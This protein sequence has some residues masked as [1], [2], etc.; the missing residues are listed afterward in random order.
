MKSSDA[1]TMA[2]AIFSERKSPFGA[3][4]LGSDTHQALTIPD[5][6]RRCHWIA[7]DL[8]ASEFGL[9]FV[10]PSVERPRLI[11]CFDSSYP[12]VSAATKYISGSNGE[13]IVKHTR[14]STL[15]RWWCDGSQSATALALEGLHEAVR[16][17]ELVPSIPGIAF[18]VYADRGQ[19]GLVV[20]LGPQM[21]LSDEQLVEMHA[22]SFALFN[23]VSLIRPGEMAKTPSISKRELECL[24]LAAKGLTSEDMAEALKLS[25][26]TVN[27]YLTSITQKLNAVNRMH[28]VA[29]ALRSGMIE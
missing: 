5:A 21:A 14:V 7:I 9:F 26:H 11:P 13:E 12:K 17:A 25:T 6:V 16:I 27:Q 8:N 1:K 4:S 19:C 15:A 20:F 2:E 23:A 18:P 24:K 28:A 29:K 10:S 3:F 22:R